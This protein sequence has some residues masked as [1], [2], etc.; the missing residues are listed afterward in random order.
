VGILNYSFEL[1]EFNS[2]LQDGSLVT[3]PPDSETI[4]IDDFRD[5]IHFRTWYDAN[6][7]LVLALENRSL[8]ML[9]DE[10]GSMTW[11]DSNGDRYTYFKRLLNKL[12][13]TYPNTKINLVGFGGLLTATNIFVT[14]G[15]S[16]ASVS[17]EDFDLLMLDAFQNSV[18]DFAGVRV[19]RRSYDPL[20]GG[21]NS[22]LQYP[23]DPNDG[24]LVG[25]GILQSIKDDNLTQGAMYYYG[26]WSYNKDDHASVPKYVRAFPYDR[27]LPAGVHF[28]DASVRVLTGARRDDYTKLIYNF[29]EG[30]DL[31]V[32]DSSSSGNHGIINCESVENF[33]S[34]D[35]TI[36]AYTDDGLLKSRVGV[37]FN[38]LNDYI[39]SEADAFI[40]YGLAGVVQPLTVCFWLYRYQSSS[41]EWVVGTSRST[42]SN[43]AGWAIGVGATGEV[44]LGFNDVTAGF[45]V[46]TGALVPLKVWTHVAVVL[47]TDQAAT[48]YINGVATS[49]SIGSITTAQMDA[50]YVGGKPSISWSGSNYF[51]SLANLSISNTVRDADYIA[52]LHS[53]E[54][55]IFNESLLDASANPVDNG[56]REVVLRWMIGSGFNFPGGNVRIV[57]KYNSIPSHDE[58]G[59]TVLERAAAAG[60]FL[61]VDT[62]NLVHGGDY[63]Y[64]FFT[65][66]PVMDGSNELYLVC[67]RD[68]ARYTSILVPMIVHASDLPS[69]P[70]ISSLIA[71]P[72]DR[73]IMLEWLNPA[74][75]QY[76][77]TKIFF[78]TRTYPMPS[79][80][81]AGIQIAEGVEIADTT[82]THFIHRVLGR[83]EDGSDIALAN[84]TKYYYT[85][86]TYNEMGV[87]S[88]PTCLS[89][90]PSD[91]L[92]PVFEPAEVS[93]FH[94]EIVNPRSLSLQWTNPIVKSE[95]IVAYMGEVVLVFTSVRDIYGGSPENIDNMT[96]E[97]WAEYKTRSTEASSTELGYEPT[98]TS[99][100]KN[101]NFSGEFP[102]TAMQAGVAEEIVI[103]SGVVSSGLLKGSVGH[104]ANSSVLA[105]RETYT[106]LV[107]AKYK[108]ADPETDEDVFIF[109]S[110]PV[111]IDFVNP[112]RLAI[113]N[114]HNRTVL[115][116]R[117]AESMRGDVSVCECPDDSGGST[118]P[119][120]VPG[121]YINSTRP[122]VARIEFQFK[123][124]YVPEGHPVSISIW[125]D[126]ERTTKPKYTTVTEGLYRSSMVEVEDTDGHVIRKSFVDVEVAVPVMPETV[127]LYAA[128]TYNGFV[129][130]GIHKIVF[131]GALYIEL[132]CRKPI[133]DGVHAEE[134]FASVYMLH[135]DY[136]EDSSKRILPPDGTLVKWSIA[137]RKEGRN[138]P[139]YSTARISEFM[140]GVYSPVE[141]GLA[142]GVFFG[143]VGPDLE[144]HK[145]QYVCDEE[146]EECCLYEDYI[147]TAQTTYGDLT[148]SDSWVLAYECDDINKNTSQR[149]FINA[150]ADW[151]G[152]QGNNP[153]W[154]TWADGI[155]ML[156]FQIAHNP[157][158]PNCP[159][160]GADCFVQCVKAMNPDAPIFALQ[161]GT[162]VSVRAPGEVLWGVSFYEDPYTGERCIAQVEHIMS[163]KIAEEQGLESS[164]ANIEIGDGYATDFYVRMNAVVESDPHEMPLPLTMSETNPEGLLPNEWKGICADNV[165]SCSLPVK[166]VKWNGVTPLTATA[167]I[168]VQMGDEEVETQLVGGGDYKTGIPPV[169][170]GFKEP[171][172]GEIIQV[173]TSIAPNIHQIVTETKPDGTPTGRKL[174]PLSEVVDKG[175]IT[176]VVEATF[177]SEPVP[178][179]TQVD[180]E[181][182]G[183]VSLASCIGDSPDCFVSSSGVIMIKNVNDPYINPDDPDNPGS[184]PAKSLAYFTID[185]LSSTQ[186]SQGQVT[187]GS[188]TGSLGY[189]IA[190]I[191]YD[192]RG[193]LNST[194]TATA[195]FCE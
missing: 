80:T 143:P 24:D 22:P 192:K 87:F 146:P 45:S 131:M 134:Q 139:F 184:V 23:Q 118:S 83:A 176:I 160:P 8:S 190:Y 90:S 35:S 9:L 153:E 158:D 113:V 64:R 152:N 124:T 121:A 97:F 91:A 151:D 70:G 44:L 6:N 145:L 25:D 178:D 56:Q 116:P 157:A 108:I 34:G 10:S 82:S 1:S 180:V 144:E 147:I 46:A 187:V 49:V 75:S 11:N 78:G 171:L 150:A 48:V 186:F 137:P 155:H 107:R 79:I 100:V 141:N 52:G 149:M 105:R 33:W 71:T 47:R 50:L 156:K 172:K 88:A 85:V 26:I 111:R 135:P 188:S 7:S 193:D 18:Y 76:R 17:A 161:P 54:S 182:G 96:Y 84:G 154:I 21:P 130:D 42:A 36:T 37:R 165:D 72:G 89:A 127:Y 102:T 13:V 92:D 27:D 77:G 32:L 179:N 2:S 53:F 164:L 138:R 191:D 177:A 15:T 55:L 30:Q 5:G 69:P 43:S 173:R 29:N 38:G 104:I 19:V 65:Y 189:I 117:S 81:T 73:K 140:S 66:R 175:Y 174:L 166:G 58:D 195:G 3:S 16:A 67:D 114:K 57:R 110:E 163:E 128:T 59:T 60:E 167:S 61:Y 185:P 63:F 93:D 40:S 101:R 86:V 115:P 99:T 103:N 183:I 98:I 159:V 4:V 120:P 194:T 28:A 125:K 136:P 109:N 112:I 122:Y 74:D 51:G 41:S 133:P 169:L 148:A 123:G 94:A 168:I 95:Q 39:S 162:I 12:K 132:D 62:D 142:R 119:P 68:D 106:V 170:V 20:R 31:A 126:K 129:A 181:V 14:R